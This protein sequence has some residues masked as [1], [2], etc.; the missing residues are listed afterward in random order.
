MKKLDPQGPTIEKL[1]GSWSDYTS[2]LNDNSVDAA[3]RITY[4]DGR[5]DFVIE[6]ES[7][8]GNWSLRLS[9]IHQKFTGTWSY[10]R[11]LRQFKIEMQLYQS[12][13]DSDE[14]LLLGTWEQPSGEITH[15]SVRLWPDEDE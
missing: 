12:A 7:E 14:L 15:G 4:P 8:E 1:D 10:E 5:E 3:R 11:D 13:F 6:A 2:G 9:R